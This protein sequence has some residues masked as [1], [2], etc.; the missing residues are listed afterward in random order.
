MQKRISKLKFFGSKNLHVY[1]YGAEFDIVTDNKAVELIFGNSD[2]KPKARIERWCLRLLPYKF[3][4]KHKPGASNIADYISRNPISQQSLHDHEDVAERY[5][6]MIA[7]NALPK[8]ISRTEMVNETSK[9]ATDG[10][11]RLRHQ[12]FNSLWIDI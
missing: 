9:D 8:A 5:I 10:R 6:N 11:R 3:V 1:L 4:V 7:C 2:S 12:N